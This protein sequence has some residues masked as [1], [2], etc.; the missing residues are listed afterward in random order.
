VSWY[1]GRSG[2]VVDRHVPRA[3]RVRPQRRRAPGGPERGGR[4]RAPRPVAQQGAKRIPLL[5]AVEPPPG[6]VV[7]RLPSSA[8]TSGDRVEHQHVGRRFTSAQFAHVLATPPPAVG[9]EQ[10]QGRG[11]APG[12][13]RRP[14]CDLAVAVVAGIM[15]SAGGHGSRGGPPDLPEATR[16]APLPLSTGAHR[17]P[18]PLPTL[19]AA[20]PIPLSQ[21]LPRSRPRGA[22]T[23]KPNRCPGAA[24]A[25][26]L[27]LAAA[28]T[29]STVREPRFLPRRAR[30]SGPLDPWPH[31]PA[32]KGVLEDRSALLP[33]EQLLSVRA[34]RAL[35]PARAESHPSFAAPVSTTA[36]ASRRARRV[37]ARD[38]RRGT[39]G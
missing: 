12:V 16:P 34:E 6:L 1:W 35:A 29:S 33:C 21:L 38:V 13:R 4:A 30:P 7:L 32:A 25:L 20:R 5:L 10:E 37:P 31:L 27:H 24:E 11:T 22:F 3:K 14:G 26:W 9:H 28:R 39:R 8:T 15:A 18:F 23:W 2:I 36:A 19:R 17:D